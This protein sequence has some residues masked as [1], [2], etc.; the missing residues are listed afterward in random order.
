MVETDL[1]T[2]KENR[3]IDPILVQAADEPLMFLLHRN[4]RGLNH[5]LA[6]IHPA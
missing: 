3:A 6:P 1:G 2:V 5:N 4:R